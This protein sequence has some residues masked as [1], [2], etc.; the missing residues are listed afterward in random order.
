MSVPFRTLTALVATPL[1]EDYSPASETADFRRAFTETPEGRRVLAVLA[2]R[3][4]YLQA[5]MPTNGARETPLV[6]AYNE[7]RRSVAEAIAAI[8][9][10]DLSD[11]GELKV[12]HERRDGSSDDGPIGFGDQ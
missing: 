9:D 6:A 3:C 7:G 5:V 12:E 1:P 8:I 11:A 2:H 4:G 10:R